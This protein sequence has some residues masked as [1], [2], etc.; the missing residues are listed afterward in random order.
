[1]PTVRFLPRIEAFGEEISLILLSTK[2]A[3]RLLTR[4][5]SHRTID[6]VLHSEMEFFNFL[7]AII[8]T[9]AKSFKQELKSYQI[10]PRNRITSITQY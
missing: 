5:T 3:E 4:I 2:T 1:M 8:R 6:Q 9:D 7:I 10:N